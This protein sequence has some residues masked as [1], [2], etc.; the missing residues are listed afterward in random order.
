MSLIQMGDLT[1]EA[2]VW[3]VCGEAQ[4]S[5]FPQVPVGPLMHGVRQEQLPPDPLPAPRWP[6]GA[7]ASSSAGYLELQLC[8]WHCS[9]PLGHISG[10]NKDPLRFQQ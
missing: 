2:E 10:Q 9:G 3:G 8:A 7:Q 6:S 1:L 4:D 5:L